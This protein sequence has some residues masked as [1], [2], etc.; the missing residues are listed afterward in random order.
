VPSSSTSVLRTV[1]IDDE[2]DRLLAARAQATGQSKAHLFR[3]L[4]S[5]GIRAVREGRRSRASM[6]THGAP[7]VLKTVQMSPKVDHQLRVEAFDA[8]LPQNELMRQ[9]LKVGLEVSQGG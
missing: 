2:L 3:R 1:Y 9:Y 4:L 6:P 7:L 8:R 5:V